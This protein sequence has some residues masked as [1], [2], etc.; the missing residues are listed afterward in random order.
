MSDLRQLIKL[1]EVDSALL[2]LEQ[3]KGD[4][5]RRV[6]ELKTIMDTVTTS[7]ENNQNRLKEI[8]LEIRHL[9][10]SET[11]HRTKMEK[12]RDQLYLV[13]TNREYDALTSEIDHLK[14]EIDEE[15]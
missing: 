15:E 7:I 4:L 11:D 13:K 10:G 6:D 2:E 3:L 12:L 5:P 9:T 1:Q 14:S 8:E